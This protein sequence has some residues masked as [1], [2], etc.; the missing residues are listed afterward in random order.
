[1]IT[2]ST[3]LL[4]L[5]PS[6]RP[7]ELPADAVGALNTGRCL[8]DTPFKYIAPRHEDKLSRPLD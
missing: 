3:S 7:S 1:M 6:S 2:G 4:N 8:A 5:G